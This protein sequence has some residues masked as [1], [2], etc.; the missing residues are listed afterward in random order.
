MY[1]AWCF[2]PCSSGWCLPAGT[3]SSNSLP[4]KAVSILVLLD[5]AYR[6]YEVDCPQCGEFSFNPC[7]S[8]WCLPASAG[9]R[10]YRILESFNPCSSGWC[11]PALGRAMIEVKQE[12][13]NPCSSGWCLPAHSWGRPTPPWHQVSILVLLDDAYRH[14]N[15][16]SA[17]HSSPLFQSLF[18]WMMPTGKCRHRYKR[19]H[20]KVS[21][22][23]LLDDAYRPRLRT[24]MS[25]LNAVS[26]LV[27]LDD[28]YRLPDLRIKRSIICSF[29]PC[30]SGWCLPALPD[31]RIRRSIICSFN[32]CSSGWCLPALFQLLLYSHIHRFQS[33]FFWMM[34][35]G[36]KT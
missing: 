24:I 28:A 22:L 15:L 11:L 26:I 1:L 23:V 18:F 21:I 16:P 20:T 8:G 25:K 4:N 31:L 19:G 9:E 14:F 12:S 5:D 35:T 7:S 3:A 30:S 33:L 29:N 13:F 36:E 6:P 32:P 27:L 34:P 2:N 10:G 17:L